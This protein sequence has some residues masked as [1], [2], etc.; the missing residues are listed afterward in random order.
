MGRLNHAKASLDAAEQWKQRCL[1]DGG[2]LFTDERLWT[3]ENFEQLGIYFVEKFDRK[4]GAFDGKLQAQLNPAPAEVKRLC[5]EMIWVLYLPVI[6]GFAKPKTKIKRIRMVW[7]WSGAEFTDEHWALQDDVLNGFLNPGPAFGFVLW[8]EC[9][10]IVSV[11]ADWF[12]FSREKRKSLLTDP[13]DFAAWL[14]ERQSARR[15]LF[16]HACPFLLFPD[17]FEPI[18][19]RSH[20]KDIVRAFFGKWNK[21][22]P[23][24]KDNIALD[25]ALLEIRSRLEKEHPDQE[26]Q[27]HLPPFSDVWRPDPASSQSSATK[28]DPPPQPEPPPYDAQAALEGLFLDNRQFERIL[29]SIARGKNLILQGP[30][31]VGKTYIARRIA[32]CLTGSKDPHRIEMVQFHQ[33][34]AYEDFVQGWRPNDA[35]GFTLRNGVF[36]AF[37]ARARKQPEARFVFIIDEINR[38]NL[39]RIFGELL[40]LIEA[41]KRGPDHAIPLTYSAD[42]ERFSVPENVYLLGMMNTA[43][44]SLAMV[45]YALRRRF[46]FEELRPAYGSEKFREYLI[47]AG[48]EHTLVN[49]IEGNM[50]A[51]NTTIREDG[52]LGPGF[53]IGHSFFVPDDADS[54]DDRWYDSIIETKIAPLL[55]EYWFDRPQRVEELTAKLRQ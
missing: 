13:W 47:E 17:S 31:G 52:D 42:G 23:D 15:R 8:L 43:D 6:S 18:V 40:M 45:D 16:S 25:R 10:F 12:S 46:A 44:R 26:V 20:K 4:P 48:I 50:A 36:F 32:W 9:C 38:G 3:R 55:R 54:A 33:S 21:T 49:R 53:E 1:L 29:V 2:S 11:M 14:Y 19:N 22:P 41:D 37:C 30:P 51:V 39:S 34:Y 27:F 7:E 28:E 5:A 24:D 35:G